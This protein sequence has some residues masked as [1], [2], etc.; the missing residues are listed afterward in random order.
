MIAIV[1]MGMMMHLA[2]SV[3]QKMAG[4]DRSDGKG[5]NPVLIIM[6]VLFCQQQKYANGE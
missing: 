1:G 2:G 4:N 5:E 3:I 6:P